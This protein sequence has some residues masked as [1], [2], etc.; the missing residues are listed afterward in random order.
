V[1]DDGSATLLPLFPL[2]H[3]L[4]PGCPLPLRIFEPRYRRLLADV[5]EE[6]APRRFGVV[7]LTAGSEVQTGPDSPAPRFAGVGTVAEILEVQSVPDG[8][9][10]VLTGGSSRFRIQRTVETGAPYLV[11]EVSYLDEIDGDLSDGLVDAVR[12]LS[13]EYTRLFSVLTATEQAAREPYPSDP[14]LL[15]YRLASEAPLTQVDQ[16]LLLEDATA[17]ARMVHLQ[18]VLRRELM[19]LR[20]TRTVA[21]SPALLRVMLRPG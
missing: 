1:A 14:S 16:Q 5:T 12:A 17:A 21:V 15:S 4:M 20:R 9:M 8:T 13:T 2:G 7:A 6:G 18:R 19:L 11:A 3:V 10:G